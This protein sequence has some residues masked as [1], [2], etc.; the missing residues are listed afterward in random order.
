MNGRYSK[1][2]TLIELM[3]AVVVIGIL[4]AIAYP[5]YIQQVIRSNRNVAKG[6]LM[7]LAQ[8]MER[9]YSLTGRYDQVPGGG[10]VALPFAKSPQSGTQHYTLAISAG[11]TATTYTLSATP[12]STQQQKDTAC[13]T[14]SI[15]S[16]GVKAETGTGSVSDCWDK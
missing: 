13:G 11:P 16:A 1:G 15:T 14:L 6:D 5:S 7:Q 12:F 9:N 4:A 2:F 3:I 10:A 8:F